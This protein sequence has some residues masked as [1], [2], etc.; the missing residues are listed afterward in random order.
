MRR[1]NSPDLTGKVAIVTGAAR[2]LGAGIA[3]ALA[4]NGAAVMLTDVLADEGEAT[5]ADLREEGHSA[6]FRRHDVSNA[7]EWDDAVAATISEFGRIDCLVNNAG[8][9]FVE[10]IETAT[11]DQFRRILDVNVVGTFIGMQKV[12]PHMRSVGGGSIVNISSNSTRKV[13]PSTTIYSST[14]A[15]VANLTKVVAATLGGDGI[16][17]NSVHP[18]AHD[19][20]M[21]RSGLA[22]APPSVREAVV[23]AIPM[24][25]MGR[26]EETG[27]LVAFLVSDAASYISGG[28]YFV[29]GAISNV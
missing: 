12:I 20:E 19:T 6:G 3:W 18:G 4:E 25:R 8:I 1:T 14:K 21:V 26:P 28:E 29:D 23:R 15:A 22:E 5:T 27:T 9:N 13:V 24:G 11:E 16:R 17:V 10:T 7:T 2:G